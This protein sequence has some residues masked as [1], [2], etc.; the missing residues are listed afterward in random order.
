[1]TKQTHTESE[2]QSPDDVLRRMLSTPPSP[3]KVA[4]KKAA[5]KR[6]AK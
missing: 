3:K 2:K 5:K 1:M 4:P 6:T